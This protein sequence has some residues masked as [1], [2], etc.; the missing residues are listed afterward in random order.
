MTE[1]ELS[2]RVSEL[3]AQNRALAAEN[4]R[5]HDAL[6]SYE[7]EYPHNFTDNAELLISA[8]IDA[9][10]LQSISINKFSTPNEKIELFMSLFQGRMD[11]YAKRCYSIKYNSSYYIPACE[12]EWASG[13]CGRPAIK[14]KNCGNRKLLPLT[15]DVIERHLRNK[16]KNG[17]GIAGI[18]PL[19]SDES[20]LFLAVDFDKENW[21]NDIATFRTVCENHNI[22]VAVERSRSG[23]GGHAWIFF[24]ETV[25]AASARKM[26]NMLLTES[27]SLRH[28][29]RFASYDRM[30]PNQDFM[31]KGGFGN[32]I[33]LPLQG[34]PREKGNSEFVDEN[35]QNYTDQWAYLASLR[36]M[37]A[38]EVDMLISDL[39]RNSEIGQ[40][41]QVIFDNEEIQ[42][43]WESK[44]PAEALAGKDFP[45]NL[46]VVNANML[47]VTKSG[48][49]QR[50]LN[51]IKRLAAFQNPKYYQA[52]R[53]RMSTHNIPRIICSLDETPEYLGIPRGCHTVFVELLDQAGVKYAFADKKCAGRPINVSFAGGVGV[54]PADC[55]NLRE[56]AK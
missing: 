13:I 19:L 39:H 22:P 26:G 10:S 24:E 48:V 1:S 11:V 43:P 2:R 42:K 55:V 36:K 16:D 44:K 54:Y 56:G 28:E 14:C 47:Y 41:E 35:F 17:A 4:K 6:R 25:M 38:T 49:S 53:M 9:P 34:G 8:K 31:P 5:L 40:L 51:R 45:G 12:N 33:A 3:E 29:I 30:F 18:Y 52:Q 20:C 23:N 46:R 21:Q 50:A 32:L 15:A 27:M 7:V 37:K